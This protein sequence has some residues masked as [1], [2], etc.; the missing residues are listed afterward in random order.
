MSSFREDGD[1]S[2]IKSTSDYTR[3]MLTHDEL[4]DAAHCKPLLNWWKE[5][6]EE[7]LGLPSR[8]D[9]NPAA[10][11]PIL[12]NIVIFNLVFSDGELVDLFPTLIGTELTRVY[13][14][15]T[16][17]LLSEH[18]SEY[19]FQG[20]LTSARECLRKGEPLGVEATAVTQEMPFMRSYSLYCPLA[21]DHTHI[22]KIIVQV[23]FE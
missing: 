11:Q 18:E 13:G 17:K 1:I 7:E 16:G 4:Q 21:T 14:E 15:K 6:N 10:F 19:I 9:F 23:S 12:P 2:A 5:K 3:R 22:D 20:V 8:K